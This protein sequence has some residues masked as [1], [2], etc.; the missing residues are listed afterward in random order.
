LS[1]V[2]EVEGICRMPSRRYVMSGKR[3]QEMSVGDKFTSPSKTIT[4]TAITLCVGLAGMTARFFNDAEAAGK[5]PLGWQAAPGRMTLMMMG[6]LEEQTEIW[7]EPALL[8]GFN[9]VRF[10]KPVMAGDT[11]HIEMEIIE[12]RETSKPGQGLVVHRSVCRNQRNEAVLEVDNVHVV[13]YRQ[14]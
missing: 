14:E 3:F 7:A 4:E 8:S 9:N 2:L 1:E 11:I 6:G 12:K 10:R 13:N 5:T